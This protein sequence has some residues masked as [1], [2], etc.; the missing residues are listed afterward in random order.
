MEDELNERMK[1]VEMFNRR[2]EVALSGHKNAS[3]KEVAETLTAALIHLQMEVEGIRK[4]IN[5]L[6]CKEENQVHADEFQKLIRK[7]R[8]RSD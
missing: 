8:G 1:D 7:R 6:Q 5:W 4:D 3:C 2:L